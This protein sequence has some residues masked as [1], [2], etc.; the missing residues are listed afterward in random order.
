[1]NEILD[2]LSNKKLSKLLKIN[3]GTL[4]TILGIKHFYNLWYM[5]QIQ[6]SQ[7]N[8]TKTDS[9]IIMWV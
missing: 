1:M 7:E 8:C 6:R 5:L 9:L 3:L 2:T 4:C